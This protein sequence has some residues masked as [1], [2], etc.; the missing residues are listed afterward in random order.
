MIILLMPLSP[1]T[2]NVL[3]RNI[4]AEKSYKKIKEYIPTWFEARFKLE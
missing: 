1:K 2:W 4:R 3:P